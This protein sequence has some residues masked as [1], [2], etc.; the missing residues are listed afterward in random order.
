MGS[1]GEAPDGGFAFLTED[2]LLGDGDRIG[3]RDRMERGPAVGPQG[4]AAVG[5]QGAAAVGPQGAAG[6]P[7]ARETGTWLGGPARGGGPRRALIS[8]LLA[9]AGGAL[10]GLLAAAGVRSL[11]H[12]PR[13][14]PARPAPAPSQRAAPGPWSETEH[15]APDIGRREWRTRRAGQSAPAGGSPPSNSESVAAVASTAG[16]SHGAAETVSRS[17]RRP[18]ASPA[19]PTGEAEFGF[20]R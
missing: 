11:G 12:L 16:A 7:G 15:E 1:A 20:E 8:A 13:E 2:E 18:A 6:H 10:I 17:V 3:P 5:P 9:G 14:Q 4:A 19:Q